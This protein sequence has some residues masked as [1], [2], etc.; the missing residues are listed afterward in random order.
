MRASRWLLILL[1][2]A[3]GFLV[4]EGEAA[5][6]SPQGTGGIML[7]PPDV[8]A[9]VRSELA[10]AKEKNTRAALERFIRRHPGH[11]LVEDARRALQIME[12]N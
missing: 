11:P 3:P 1:L 8:D 2:S 5:E 7:P 4:G 12:Q 9:A 6:K 10:R